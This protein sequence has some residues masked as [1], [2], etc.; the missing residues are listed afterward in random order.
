MTGNIHDYKRL[1][2]FQAELMEHLYDEPKAF[3]ALIGEYMQCSEIAY[4]TCDTTG[5]VQIYMFEA[6]QDQ[7]RTKSLILDAGYGEL[8][9]LDKEVCQAAEEMPGAVSDLMEE[10]QIAGV[11]AVTTVS[12]EVNHTMYSMIIFHDDMEGVD[13]ISGI[14][15]LLV[16]NIQ[17]CIENR[18]FHEMVAYESEHDLL[19]KL[20]NRRCYFRRST[21]EYPLLASVGVFYF[22]VNNLKYVN[23]HFGHDAGD[24]LLQKA[25]ESIRALTSDTVHGYRMG[26]DEFILVS[27]NCTQNDMKTLLARWEKELDS[28]NKKYGGDLCVVAVG[29]AFAKGSFE[30]EEVCQLADKR[31]YQDKIRKKKVYHC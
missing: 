1:V 20:Y 18:I 4:L 31:M 13:G 26:G 9:Q 17:I 5:V 2:G 10:W 19:T 24:A 28:V 3:L 16:N 23:D 7:C 6:E 15:S 14:E 21:E 29:S 11:Q 30:I 12:G 22:D 8:F 27:M 25:A